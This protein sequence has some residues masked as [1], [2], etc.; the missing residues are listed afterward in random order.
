MGL[1]Y[2]PVFNNVLSEVLDILEWQTSDLEI[3]ICI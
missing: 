2:V 1:A 3:L